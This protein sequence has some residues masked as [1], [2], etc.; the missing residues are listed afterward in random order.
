MRLSFSS[1]ERRGARCTTSVDLPY[2]F[3]MRVSFSSWGRQGARCTT[4]VDL[5][6]D[7]STRRSSYPSEVVGGGLAGLFFFSRFWFV[8]TVCTSCLQASCFFSTFW[9]FFLN[10]LI[11]FGFFIFWRLRF[12]KCLFFL[13]CSI[14]RVLVFVFFSLFSFSSY[15]DF[16]WCWLVFLKVLIFPMFDFFSRI[17]FRGCCF[18]AF[19]MFRFSSR[20]W[21]PWCW[22]FFGFPLQI[23]IF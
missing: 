14:F 19:S 5:P 17:R 2:D 3:F 4:S 7:F 10:V 23:L 16:L 12:S 21:F 6:C 8:L 11:W 13:E 15:F 18:F 20:F 22:V 1:W 9:C